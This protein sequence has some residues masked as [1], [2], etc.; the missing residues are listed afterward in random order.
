MQKK[1]F[2]YWPK[3]KLQSL[4]VGKFTVSL[5][6]EQ[7]LAEFTIRT[8]SYSYN[9]VSLTDL[10][11]HSVWFICSHQASCCVG[12]YIIVSGLFYPSCL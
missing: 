5:T 2:A 7:Q 8:L 4:T 1:C 11:H 6:E 12:R 10:I 3:D 9:Q